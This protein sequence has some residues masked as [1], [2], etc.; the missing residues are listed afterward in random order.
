MSRYEFDPVTHE[1]F[2]QEPPGRRDIAVTQRV[3]FAP[4][5]GPADRRRTEHLKELPVLPE[6]DH[7]F[8]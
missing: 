3:L 5:D 1:P 7:T 6:R 4:A 2:R 8:N